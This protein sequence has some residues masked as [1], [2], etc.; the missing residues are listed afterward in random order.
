[1]TNNLVLPL[2]ALVL[3][4]LA[5]LF[6]F[7]R[8]DQPP[9]GWRGRIAGTRSGSL[10]TAIAILIF[11]GATMVWPTIFHHGKTDAL[12]L[13][14]G[15]LVAIVAATADSKSEAFAFG[16]AVFGASLLHLDLFSAGEVATAQVAFVAGAFIAAFATGGLRPTLNGGY[17]CAL[18]AI[19]VVAVDFL[20]RM[21]AVTS[22]SAAS[23][24]LY[25]GLAFLASSVIC[26]LVAKFAKSAL[27]SGGIGFIA[28]VLLGYFGCY[29]FLANT[30]LANLWLGGA[31]VGG[32]IHLMLN[33]DA[34]AEP[35]RIVLATII[36][37]AAATVAFSMALGYGMAVSML[38][39]ASVLFL[40]GNLRGL[41]TMS[42]AASV[43]VYRLF[44]EIYPGDAKA[45]DI[46]Q[47]YTMIGIAMGALLPLL[48]IEWGRTRDLTGWK[49]KV[50][51][52][53]W[54]LILLGLPVPAAVLLG[55]KGAIG[56]V[57]GLSFA[58]VIEGIR[59]SV[60]LAPVGIATGVGALT[61]LS[62]DWLGDWTDLDRAIKVRA[63]L[64][65]SV[66]A[67]FFA[68][69]LFGLSRQQATK[70]EKK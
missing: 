37:L 18:S 36:W 67:F 64:I 3:A 42:V 16:I 15:A 49:S 21:N 10:L 17:L 12:A 19:F 41:M 20:G 55:S 9:P 62:Y 25:L 58:A 28:I 7:K 60:S 39:G 51:V 70:P 44:R 69:A 57:I 1:M 54:L 61:V 53:L 27:V 45:P 23:A 35:F 13:I 22:V 34:E 33:G 43:L 14:F 2:L 59:G 47:H 40:F 63:V 24:G 6:P 30:T 68:A 11:G 31:V 48:P 52:A 29:Q 8:D 32:V 66:V 46:G 5:A 4:V 38:G 50:A 56:M 65:V 26:G